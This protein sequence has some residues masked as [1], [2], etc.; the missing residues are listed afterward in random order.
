L[1]RLNARTLTEWRSTQAEAQGNRCALCGDAFSPKN[2]PV[3]D[4]CHT[5]GL[6][7]KVLHR[8]CNAALGHVENNAPRYFLTDP[9][10]LAKWARNIAPYINPA[11]YPAVYHPTHKTDDEKRELRNK[12]ARKARAAKKGT[13]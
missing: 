8:G 4:H 11:Q 10:R 6:M 7:R 3:G 12:R 2:P 9:V 5:T 13:E 1:H